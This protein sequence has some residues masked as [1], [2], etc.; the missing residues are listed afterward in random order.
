MV[1][2][3]DLW[4]MGVILVAV[5]SCAALSLR[6]VRRRRRRE[7][8]TREVLTEDEWFRRYLPEVSDHRNALA[9]VLQA[10]GRHLD[11]PWTCLRPDDTFSGSL[12]VRDLATG[13]EELLEFECFLEGWLSMKR[14]QLRNRA[15]PDELA[16]FLREV[17]WSLTQT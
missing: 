6:S 16:T 17:H 14:L 2:A 3:L 1:T 12:S 10:L 5:V 4:I 8:I 11:V 9:E 7:L 15:L 13:D